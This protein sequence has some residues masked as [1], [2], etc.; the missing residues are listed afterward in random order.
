[1]GEV[2]VKTCYSFVIYARDFSSSI[3]DSNGDTVAQGTQD[4][5]AHVGT[6]HFTVKACIEDIG[7]ANIHPGDVMLFNDPYRGG[8][9]FPDV[10]VVRPVFIATN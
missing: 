8:T 9:H 3:T 6:L 1:M 7:R 2:V 5:A 4:I 10:R